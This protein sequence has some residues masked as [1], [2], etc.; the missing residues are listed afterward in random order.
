MPETLPTAADKP[1]EVGDYIKRL[2]F[3]DVEGRVISVR[4]VT[5]ERTWIKLDSDRYG[6]EM[7]I[8]PDTARFWVYLPVPTE[9]TP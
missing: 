7:A 1:V 3:P 2:F 6:H 9:E 8:E 4:P 5:R